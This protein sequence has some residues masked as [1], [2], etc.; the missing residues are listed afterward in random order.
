ML[1][2]VTSRFTLAA[3]VLASLSLASSAAHAQDRTGWALNRYEP[4]PMGDHFFVA[5]HPW[6]SSVRTFSVGLYGDYAINPLILRRTVDGTTNNVDNI[7][8]TFSLHVGAQVSFL[9]RIGVHVSLPVSLLQSGTLASEVPV[10]VGPADG[11]A[12]GD[13]RVGLRVRLFGQADKDGFSMHL[14]GNFWA[15]I[16]QRS[17]NTGDEGIRIEPRLTLAGRGGPIRWSLGFGF[18]VRDTT[19]V[20]NLAFGSELRLSAAVGLVAANDRLTIGP[21]LYFATPLRDLNDTQGGGSALFNNTQAGGEVYLGARYLIADAVTVGLAGGPGIMQGPGIPT[22]RVIFN[23]AYAPVRREAPVMAPVDTDADGVFDPDDQ[24]PTTPQGPNPDPARRGCPLT[25]TDSDGVF[26]NEDQCVSEPMGSTPDPTRRGCPLRDRD[27]DGV[28]DADD[29]CVD[30]PQGTNPDPARRGCPAGDRD[31]D[32]VFDH[33]DQCP[34]ESREPFPDP[35]RNG[36]PLPDADHDQV[37][38][39]PDAC[40]G[41]AGVP[42]PDP[43]RNGCP[44]TDVRLESGQIRILQQVFFDTDR[45]TIK[46]RSF[47][48]LQAVAD[49]LRG[50]P[51]IRRVSVDGHTDNRADEAHNMD[52]SQ[53]RAGSV[54]RWLVE[55]GVEAT[56]LEPHG[57]GPTRPIDSNENGA[58]RA[59][60]RRV[61]FVIIDP[62]QPAGVVSQPAAQAPAPQTNDTAP[63]HR[64]HRRH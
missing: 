48:I 31:R 1:A 15:P 4:A 35:A 37:P 45:D 29:Q 27:G 49:V 9:D 10:V 34:D 63:R 52:L 44:N 51:H 57:Y 60:N 21:E 16:G 14:G 53:R 28:L 33:E 32:G 30:V 23:V 18:M 59:R 7:T 38:E 55:H 41:V 11:P 47:R 24:C 13:L 5:E 40:P 64:R 39:P 19:D 46:R 42:S 25:D 43:A 56:R 22:A 50:A 62:P 6:Y 3:V 17:S 54:V 8:G 36:C 26:D 61:E 12:I 2:P 58:G 20:L